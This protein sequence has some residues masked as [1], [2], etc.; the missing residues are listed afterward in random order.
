MCH[1]LLGSGSS[2]FGNVLGA[3]GPVTPSMELALSALVLQ[4]LAILDAMALGSTVETLVVSW[5]HIPFALSFLLFFPQ[6]GSDVF[7]CS[8]S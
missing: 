6:E 7:F 4:L 8:W 3:I 2:D 1:S 5:W